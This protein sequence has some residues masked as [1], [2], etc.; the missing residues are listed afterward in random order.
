M[1]E[2]YF[3]TFDFEMRSDFIFSACELLSSGRGHR[4]VHAHG[5][6]GAVEIVAICRMV[7][8][9]H[10]PSRL[11]THVIFLRWGLVGRDGRS[12]FFAMSAHSM[13]GVALVGML[14]RSWGLNIRSSYFSG[15]HNRGRVNF[16]IEHNL[17]KTFFCK[18][19]S[20]LNFTL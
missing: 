16:I 7:I 2:M 15:F 11:G 14:R 5:C 10:R 1:F 13:L 18:W 4:G 8:V 6:G 20:L 12:R 3:K 9:I 19:W 17:Y